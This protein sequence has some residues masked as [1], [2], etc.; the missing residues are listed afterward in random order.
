MLKSNTLFYSFFT[1]ILENVLRFLVA[2][3]SKS[4]NAC[5]GEKKPL[6]HM[7]TSRKRCASSAV[8]PLCALRLDLSLLPPGNFSLNRG[9]LDVRI[10]KQ[11]LEKSLPIMNLI[12][13]RQFSSDFNPSL[14]KCNL[15]DLCSVLEARFTR[16]L[17]C[18]DQRGT[19]AAV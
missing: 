2:V 3:S 19:W 16:N 6:K 11:R 8:I 10:L 9:V 17:K 18:E 7:E 13:F 12:F 15:H 4:P 5:Q 1:I 14:V